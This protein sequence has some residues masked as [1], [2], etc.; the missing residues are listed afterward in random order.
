MSLTLERF[1]EASRLIQDNFYKKSV[2][3]KFTLEIRGLFR[4]IGRKLKKE[5]KSS[6][7][8]VREIRDSK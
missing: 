5:G 2:K 3:K 6:V 4:D 1:C 7:D 8:L